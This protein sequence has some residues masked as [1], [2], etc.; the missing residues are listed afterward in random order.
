MR[1]KNKV[2]ALAAVLPLAG[3]GLAAVGASPAHAAATPLPA[4]PATTT[5]NLGSS[6]CVTDDVIMNDPLD[7]TSPITDTYGSGGSPV[8]YSQATPPVTYSLKY[9]NSANVW[10]AGPPPG[11]QINKTT[12]VIASYNAT[13]SSRRGHRSQDWTTGSSAVPSGS[14]TYTVRDHG[15]DSV[16]AV[17]TE[18]FQLTVNDSGSGIDEVTTVSYEGNTST[19]RTVRSPSS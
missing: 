3:I 10:I 6:N 2:L 19:M 16:G 9:L 11:T 13:G 7:S 1:I 17:G 4:Y 5:L 8:V 14:V 15:T 18:Q 12:G